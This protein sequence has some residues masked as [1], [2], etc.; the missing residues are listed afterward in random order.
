[1]GYG[2]IELETLLGVFIKLGMTALVISLAVLILIIVANW[3]LFKKAG[4]KGWKSLIPV[5]NTITIIKIAG[6]SPWLILGYFAAAI[7]VIGVV[8]CLGITIYIYAK[9]AQAFGKGAGFTVGLVLLN[10][11]FMMI[12]AFGSA[13]YQLKKETTDYVDVNNEQ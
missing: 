11:I 13:E 8:V 6:L 10:T 12:L 9:L 4:E 5:Y 3:K 2:S 1:M 7:P